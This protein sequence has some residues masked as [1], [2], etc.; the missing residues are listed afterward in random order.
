VYV[1]NSELQTAG[2]IVNKWK[3]RARV[4]IYLGCSPLHA[5]SVAFVLNIETG[6]VS[7]Q[8]HIK[9]DPTL[10]TV[11]K[12]EHPPACLWQQRTGFVTGYKQWEH[13][14]ENKK[15]ESGLEPSSKRMKANQHG[16]QKLISFEAGTKPPVVNR[17]P[18]RAISTSTLETSNTLH[19]ASPSAVSEGAAHAKAVSTTNPEATLVPSTALASKTG[20]IIRPPSRLIEALSVELLEQA[21]PGEIFSLQATM[22]A[23]CSK[24]DPFENI[25]AHAASADPDIMYYH[26]A[27][28]EPDA[29]K[30]KEAMQKEIDGQTN[31]GNWSIIP[32]SKVP[33]NETIL[34]VSMGNALQTPYQYQGGDKME[35]Q[36]QHGWFKT[37]QRIELLG[38][39]RTSC[40]P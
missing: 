32:K 12:E 6:F 9:F 7:P 18:A 13:G 29:Q 3:S 34:T 36:T 39:L 38:D 17:P 19:G 5:S 37:N 4:R 21:I 26:E 40:H 22:P 28:R 14:M 10:N 35:S 16:H 30:F 20:R 2:A 33:E 23:W 27:M 8:F 24:E 1:L 15:Q 11:R 31:N 25:W